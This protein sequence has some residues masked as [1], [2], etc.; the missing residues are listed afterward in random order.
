MRAVYTEEK[1]K[2]KIKKS[3]CPQE[4]DIP[5]I[6]SRARPDSSSVAAET[7]TCTAAVKRFLRQVNGAAAARCD[8]QPAKESQGRC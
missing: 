4:E 7:P 8:R 6:K 3:R 2:K 1:V 5:E